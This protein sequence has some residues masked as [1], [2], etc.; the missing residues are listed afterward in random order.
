MIARPF[1]SQEI[2]ADPEENESGDLQTALHA[3]WETALAGQ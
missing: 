1:V 3:R 2:K